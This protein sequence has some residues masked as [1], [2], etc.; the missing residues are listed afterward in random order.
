MVDL[1]APGLSVI[2]MAIPEL[3][4]QSL[5]KLDANLL[6][7]LVHYQTLSIVNC[8]SSTNA[9]AKR[10][11]CRWLMCGNQVSKKSGKFVQPTTMLFAAA[12]SIRS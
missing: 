10:L 8:E 12:T 4:R 5:A 9:V 3:V 11:F 1:L 7:V 6:I 2:A